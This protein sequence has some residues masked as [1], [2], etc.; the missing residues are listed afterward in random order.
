MGGTNSMWAPDRIDSPTT[1]TSSCSA[2]STIICGV[3]RMPV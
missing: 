2:D 1:S 3:C